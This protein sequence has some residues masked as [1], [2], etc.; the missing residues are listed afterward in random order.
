VAALG[1]QQRQLHVGLGEVRQRGV[2]ELMQRPP[3]LGDEQLRGAAV[4]QARAAGAEQMSQAAGVRAGLGRRLEEHGPARRPAIR[5]GSSRALPR[6][7]EQPVDVAALR[8]RPCALGGDVEILDVETQN[9]VGA[10]GGLVEQPPQCVRT[11]RC[12]G[13]PTATPLKTRGRNAC[14][15]GRAPLDAAL[16]LDVAGDLE[17]LGARGSPRTIGRSRRGGSTSPAM[18]V[19]PAPRVDGARPEPVTGTSPSSSSTT[20]SV[21]RYF[22]PVVGARSGCDKNASIAGGEVDRRGGGEAEAGRLRAGMT[23]C[24]TARPPRR[25]RPRR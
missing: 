20:I 11:A 9:F 1:H 25:T 4:G 18:C 3:G 2:T 14:G 5:R 6:A 17:D 15:C 19:T 7:E 24:S 12:P 21:W 23:D 22:A 10:G 8:A 13:A 16:Q